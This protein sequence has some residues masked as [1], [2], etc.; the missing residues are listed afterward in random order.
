MTSAMAPHSQPRSSLVRHHVKFLRHS[1]L[2]PWHHK[3]RVAE[4][5]V[6]IDGQLNLGIMGGENRV[7]SV[8]RKLF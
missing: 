5:Q 4:W 1:G 8:D 2:Q 6:A 7:G 3:W